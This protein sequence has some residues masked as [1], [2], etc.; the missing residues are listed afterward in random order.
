MHS[1]ISGNLLE[2]FLTLEKYQKLMSTG[3][4][5]QLCC[6]KPNPNVLYE[7]A[8][9]WLI[10]TIKSKYHPY[11]RESVT[12]MLLNLSESSYLPFQPTF[13][14]QLMQFCQSH[15]HGSLTH[16]FTLCIWPPMHRFKVLS[17]LIDHLWWWGFFFFNF[18]TTYPSQWTVNFNLLCLFFSPFI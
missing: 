12:M 11:N 7:H 1:G 6:L 9:C 16:K 14:H 15:R 5:M 2:I 3:Y 17:L 4:L 10:K 8:F 13:K 18:W